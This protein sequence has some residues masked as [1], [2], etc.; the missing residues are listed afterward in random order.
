MRGNAPNIVLQM[1]V[2]SVLLDRLEG[3]KTLM[4]I[5]MLTV[6]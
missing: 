5:L 4:L 3:T 2:R 6:M 1:F